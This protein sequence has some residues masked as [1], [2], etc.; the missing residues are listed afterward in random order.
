VEVAGSTVGVHVVAAPVATE[1]T[2]E[3]HSVDCIHCS[4]DII[5]LPGDC[6]GANNDKFIGVLNHH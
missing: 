5:G 6:Q 4:Y 3:R 2:T 1:A